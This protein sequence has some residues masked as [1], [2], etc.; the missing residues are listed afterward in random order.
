MFVRFELASSGSFTLQRQLID[1]GPALYSVAF[2]VWATLRR[3]YVN[4]EPLAVCVCGGG[5]QDDG[6]VAV[7]Y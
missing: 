2:P 7:L 6:F 3:I 4:V 1:Y 5:A